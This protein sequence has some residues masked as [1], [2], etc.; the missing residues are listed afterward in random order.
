MTP[1]HLAALAGHKKIVKILLAAGAD[2][3]AETTLGRTP[4]YLAQL[5]GREDVRG[6][7]VRHAE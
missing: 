2:P 6:Y 3:N 7:L 5:H 1:L 4:L